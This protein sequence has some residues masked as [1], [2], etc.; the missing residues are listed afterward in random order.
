MLISPSVSFS[1]ILLAFMSFY[2]L[3]CSDAEHVDNSLTQYAQTRELTDGACDI[4][5][6]NGC[7][8]ATIDT[9][10]VID[11]CEVPVKFFRRRCITPSGVTITIGNFVINNNSL[12]LD[13]TIYC[14]NL[15]TWSSLWAM[16]NNAG[17][18]AAWDNFRK[19]VSIA[20]E[21]MVI[22]Q[23]ISEHPGNYDCESSSSTITIASSFIETNCKAICGEQEEGVWNLRDVVCGISCCVR[24]TDYC[25]RDGVL[26]VK[27]TR[28]ESAPGCETVSND[29]RGTLGNCRNSCA[30]L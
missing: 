3:S 30:G 28:T 29:C 2:I 5:Y 24:Y 14:D 16:G 19:Q 9:V 1:F 22:L 23:F 15:D 6:Q 21:K 8:T 20:V 7:D 27:A 25:I 10:I 11:T 18:E 4:G 26:V 12:Q 17:A 13:D